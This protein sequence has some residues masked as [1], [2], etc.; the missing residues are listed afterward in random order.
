MNNQ[1]GTYPKSFP[2]A[3]NIKSEGILNV[4]DIQ[5]VTKTTAT[6]K[7]KI[8]TMNLNLKQLGLFT[9]CYGGLF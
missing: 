2:Y 1:P 4:D 9:I 5:K 8:Y 7:N 6:K 3:R